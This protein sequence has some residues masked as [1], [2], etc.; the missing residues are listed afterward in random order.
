MR[1]IDGQTVNRETCQS[2]Q[3]KNEPVTSHIISQSC[4]TAQNYVT[5]QHH[6]H[7]TI[8]NTLIPNTIVHNIKEEGVTFATDVDEKTKWN[9]SKIECYHCQRKGHIARNCPDK[10]DK[11]PTE[12]VNTTTTTTLPASDI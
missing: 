8:H 2:F 7:N 9:K 5:L 11:K 4:M 3:T 10:K 1:V 6:L 12:S